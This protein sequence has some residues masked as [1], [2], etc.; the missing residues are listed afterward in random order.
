MNSAVEYSREWQDTMSLLVES[1]N[2]LKGRLDA[3]FARGD[4]LS[5]VRYTF[6]KY[7]VGGQHRLLAEQLRRVEQGKEKRLMVFMPPRHGKSEMC[8]IRFPAYFMG[9]HPDKQIICSSYGAD[10]ARDFGRKTRNL[11]DSSEY[12]ELF[13]TRLSED[14]RA[15]DKWN[16]PE[17]GSY[18]A[19]GVG[20]ATT[21]RGADI[22]LIDDPVKDQGEAD[23]EAIREKTWEWYCSVAYTRLMPGG[24]V[25]LIMTRWHEEDLAGRLIEAEK[26]G[27][28]Q[29]TKIILPA[30]AED[31]DPLEREPGEA[32]WPEWYDLET[33]EQ[34][35]RVL[36]TG[37]GQRFWTALYQQRPAPEEGDF[38]R[39][40]WIKYYT[41]RP[42]S[43][44][45]YA[46]SDYAVTASGGDY[47]V[48]LVWGVDSFNN[49]YVVD[50][51]RSQ[52]TTD[53]WCEVQC[54]MINEWRPFTWAAEK[55]QIE[56]SVGPFL[57]T[58]MD[59]RRAYCEI[60][61]FTSVVSKAQ[62][63]QSI[64]GRMAMGK[65]FFPAA[66]GWMADIVEEMLHFPSGR[67]DDIVDA[68]A[69]AGRM[70]DEQVG[71][72]LQVL[73]KRTHWNQGSEIVKTLQEA[74]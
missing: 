42:E 49:I 9:R 59:E 63:A 66:A 45:Y 22:F 5:F 11:V 69:L 38:F 2:S 39:R 34:T 51:Y 16:T 48:L 37:G 26:S 67:N 24:A 44:L 1:R 70:L 65:V 57:R 71:P 58:M 25:I 56:K 55:G 61:L 12:A 23:S 18:V 31:D 30:I 21:G 68:L 6:P 17:G 13:E 74:V 7:Q 33:L 3:A 4:F 8:S 36:T 62:R 72:A 53:V 19:V 41:E 28:D 64:R 60:K 32:L 40:E 52:D 10:L 54:A 15:S 35:R 29:W 27:G 73:T 20:G 46:S 50:M 14:S 43:L 47:T